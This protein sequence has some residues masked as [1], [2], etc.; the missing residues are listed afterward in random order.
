V[1]HLILYGGYAVGWNERVRSAGQKEEDTAM[2]T[3]MRAGWDKYNVA[4][5]HK[6][7]QD[8]ATAPLARGRMS[9]SA[10]AHFNHDGRRECRLLPSLSRAHRRWEA[11]N[12]AIA[13]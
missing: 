11:A 12:R 1:S 3:L 8:G 7:Y 10:V 13:R 6:R 4:F 9:V 5:R 2:L